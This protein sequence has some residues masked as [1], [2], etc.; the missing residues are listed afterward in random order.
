MTETRAKVESLR[1]RI[2]DSQEI[3]EDDREVLLQFSDRLYLLKSEYTDYRHEKLLRHCTR[4]AEEVGGLA[5]ALEDREAAEELVRWINVT[6]ENEYTNHDYRTALRVFG[7]HVTES[8]GI[9][10]SLEWIPSGTSN[11]HDP[12]PN[13][14]DMLEWE[15]DVIPMIESCRNARDKALLAVAFDSGARSGELQNLTIGDVNDHRHGLQV[16]F[17]GKT[18]QRSVTLI[19]SVPYLQRWLSDHPASND[20]DAP[21]WSKLDDPDEISYRCY[22][23]IFKRAGRKAGITKPATPTNFRKSNATYLAEKG[24][25]EAFINDRQGRARGSDATAHYVARFGGRAEEEYARL[26][27][28]EVDQEEPEPIGPVKCPRCGNDTP[29]HEPAC[30]HC[31]QAL[32]HAEVQTIEEDERKVRDV[33]FRLAGEHPEIL[34]DY[35]DSRNFTELLEANPDLFREAQEF[36]DALSNE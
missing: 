12:I 31:H 29:R 9:P 26:Q 11:S 28:I 16:M 17:D 13:P 34:Q 20:G 5:D 27:G 14:A 22:L 2:Q 23:N 25:N 36:V 3:S 30:V 21:L 7:G 1:E 6:Y 10:D 4:M 35:Q 32:G 18:G 24:M 8:E 19:P 33:F 15:G